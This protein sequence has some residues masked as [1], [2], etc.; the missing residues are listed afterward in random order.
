MGLKTYAVFWDAP[1][2]VRCAGRL[3]LYAG[4]V[5]LKGAASG[6]RSEE[7]LELA[8]ITRLQLSGGRLH[9]KRRGGRPLTIG[10]LD[11]PGALREL[12]EGL[13]VRLASA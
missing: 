5:T 13:S 1:G 10:T 2:G 4:G 3:D 9:I 8:E 12:A 6:V 7:T 11:G